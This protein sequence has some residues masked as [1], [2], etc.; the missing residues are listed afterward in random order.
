MLIIA[1]HININDPE[2]FWSKAQ[3]VVSGAPAGTRV[4]AVYPSL[5]GK[6]GTCVWEGRSVEEIQNF[7]DDAAAGIATNF[8]YEVNE[9]AAL[10]LPLSKMEAVLN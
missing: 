6:T 8:C 9:S 3:K 10:G 1:H 7:L 5:D 2:T 4:H